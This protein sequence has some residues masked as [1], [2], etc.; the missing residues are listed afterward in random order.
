MYQVFNIHLQVLCRII[1]VNTFINVFLSSSWN[2]CIISPF[3]PDGNTGER[4]NAVSSSKHNWEIHCCNS[5][6]SLQFF[7]LPSLSQFSLAPS[8][9]DTAFSAALPATAYALCQL[10]SVSVLA[11]RVLR[12]SRHL[13][14]AAHNIP[15]SNNQSS[16]PSRAQL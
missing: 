11:G 13:F 15:T 12:L 14:E 5:V 10:S 6:V 4:T 8:Q 16:N 1:P 7:F 9:L 3:F 2:L